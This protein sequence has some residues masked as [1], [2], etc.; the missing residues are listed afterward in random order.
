[1]LV[2]GLVATASAFAPANNDAKLSTTALFNMEKGAGGMFDTRNPN[3]VQ[4]EDPR[5]S[6]SEA[7]SFE[8][9]LRMRSGGAAAPAPAAP[10]PAP[11][12]PPAAAWGAPPAAAPPAWGAPAPAAAPPAWGAPP[13]APAPAAHAPAMGAGGMFDTRNPNPIQHEDPRKSISAAPSFEEYLRMRDG[14]AAAAAP[15]PPAPAAAP[16]WG[17]PPAAAPV[18]ASP[19]AWGA[20]PAAA[21]APAAVGAGGSVLDTLSTLEGPGMVWGA[22]GVAISKEE[23][24]FKGF[25]NFDKF[26]AALQS[27]GVAAEIAQGG[28]YTILA[29]TNSAVE[30]YEQ[31]RGPMDANAVKLHIVPGQ[32]ASGDIRADLQSLGGPLHYRYA[33]RKHFIN[34]A[35]IGEK[36]FGPYADFPMDVTCSNGVIH[37]V[38]LCFA[39]Y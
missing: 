6:I 28:P 17:A 14:G 13:A 15:A 23:S 25:D 31:L 3:P 18:A 12:A 5:K 32:I 38:G 7:P 26:F 36:T 10:A 21:A 4:H 22:E 8:E 19:P 2:L 34:D 24:E 30:S 16:A 27:T 29:P 20:P 35:I 33:V 1:M 39:F 37:S 9:Y 11:A